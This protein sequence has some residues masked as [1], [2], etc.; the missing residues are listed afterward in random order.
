M[1]IFGHRNICRCSLYDPS[2][3]D[4]VLVSERAY[5]DEERRDKDKVRRG[6][7]CFLRNSGPEKF[8]PCRE[9]GRI[10]ACSA[11]LMNFPA[12]PDDSPDGRIFPVS[13]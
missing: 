13:G 2:P 4:L 8:Y 9:S 11:T 5:C 12:S 7:I 3:N 6:L 1:V 10:T